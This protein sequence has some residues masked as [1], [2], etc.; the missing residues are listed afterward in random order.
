VTADANDRGPVLARQHKIVLNGPRTLHEE[1]HGIITRQV[2]DR[3][4]LLESGR[5]HCRNGEGLFSRQM[6]PLT[7]GDEDAQVGA[8]ARRALTTSA[9]GSTCSKLSRISNKCFS[10][11]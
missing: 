6:Q 7:A 4:W 5:G 8:W 2:F 9:A 3:G 10:P 11:R 1:H